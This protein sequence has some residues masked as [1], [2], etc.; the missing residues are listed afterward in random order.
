LAIGDT[1][2]IK[3][4]V[5]IGGMN[6]VFGPYSDRGDPTPMDTGFTAQQ[7]V[8]SAQYTTSATKKTDLDLTVDFPTPTPPISVSFTDPALSLPGSTTLN[9]NTTNVTDGTNSAPLSSV[10]AAVNPQK[11]IVLGSVLHVQDSSSNTGDFTMKCDVAGTLNPD[12]TV[13]TPGVFGAKIAFL[14]DDTQTNS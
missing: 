7:T 11:Q 12:G 2:T 10:I 8:N 13:N 14:E 5:F 9:I 3:S 6:V 1:S 4:T